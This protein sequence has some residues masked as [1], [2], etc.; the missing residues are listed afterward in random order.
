MEI[1]IK[2]YLLPRVLFYWNFSRLVYLERQQVYDSVLGLSV[3]SKTN[4]LE[5]CCVPIFRVDCKSCR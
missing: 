4:V 2:Q 3:G 1:E 5:T